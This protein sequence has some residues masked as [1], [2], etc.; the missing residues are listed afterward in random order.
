VVKFL[1]EEVGV[2]K[3]AADGEGLRPLHVAC[4][5]WSSGDSASQMMMIRYLIQEATCDVYV[6]D[7]ENKLPEDHILWT[8]REPDTPPGNNQ[9]LR[10]RSE[11]MKAEVVA[12]LQVRLFRLAQ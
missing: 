1:I 2:D 4:K 3:N 12:M 10:L 8:D 7:A 11:S 5:K 6:L 9:L